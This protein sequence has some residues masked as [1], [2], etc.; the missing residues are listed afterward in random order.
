MYDVQEILYGDGFGGSEIPVYG[1]APGSSPLG[2]P[3]AAQAVARDPGD[4]SDKGPSSW[5]ED[6]VI[7]LTAA[8]A[9]GAG[10]IGFRF[11][12]GPGAR[13]SASVD[14]SDELS[15]LLGTVFLAIAGI[16]GFKLIV[17]RWVRIP[18]LQ[19]FAALI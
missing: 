7:W 9:V 1:M 6:P 13:A 10:I 15:E 19:E 3:R 17:F 16:V 4:R 8:F 5:W 14:I 12:W 18:A 2:S 11:H